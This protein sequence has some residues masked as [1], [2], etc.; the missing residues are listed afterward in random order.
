MGTE[1]LAPG[2]SQRCPDSP[3]SARDPAM[4]ASWPALRIIVWG[5]RV[6]V[7]MADDD[8]SVW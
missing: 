1:P 3:R 4:R 2:R 7:A 5:N 8:R 6:H